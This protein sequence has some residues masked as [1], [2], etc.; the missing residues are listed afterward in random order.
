M[1]LPTNRFD[2]ARSLPRLMHALSDAT[3]LRLVLALAEGPRNVTSLCEEIGHPQPT[4]SHHLGLLR[5]HGIVETRREGKRVIY[6]LKTTAVLDPVD[7]NS[8]ALAA[9]GY[10]IRISP[11]ETA[12]MPAI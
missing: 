12:A 8:L 1:Q 7:G 3:R 10:T 2:L 9:E 5:H 4:I 6:M 11:S